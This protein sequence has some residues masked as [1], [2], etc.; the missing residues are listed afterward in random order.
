MHLNAAK[1]RPIYLSLVTFNAGLCAK[2]TVWSNV[3]QEALQNFVHGIALENPVRSVTLFKGP[4][5]GPLQ[6]LGCSDSN[7]KTQS[8]IWNLSFLQDWTP[9][10]LRCP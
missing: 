5:D 8:E 9:R 4:L 10:P 3:H 6:A 2:Y 1:L 7:R